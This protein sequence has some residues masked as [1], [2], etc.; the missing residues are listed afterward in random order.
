MAAV[1]RTTWVAHL[2][3]LLPGTLVGALDAWSRR[4]AQ[5]HAQQRQQAWLRRQAQKHV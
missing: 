1:Q 5:R 4:V 2:V 3:R